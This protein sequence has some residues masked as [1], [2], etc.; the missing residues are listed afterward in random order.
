MKTEVYIVKCEAY[1]KADEKIAELFAL[2]GG[3]GKYAKKGERITLKANLLLAAP[4]DKAVST[5]PAIVSAVG[6]M[7]T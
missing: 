1:D 6:A 3:M 7:A 4:P 2:M 5:H